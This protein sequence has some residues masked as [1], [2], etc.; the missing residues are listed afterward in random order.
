MWCLSMLYDIIPACKDP[1]VCLQKPERITITTLFEN[2]MDYNY[3]TQTGYTYL[4]PSIM[5]G[6]SLRKCP[7]F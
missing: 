3:T 4:V 1:Y 7:K 2:K 5:L 6:Q